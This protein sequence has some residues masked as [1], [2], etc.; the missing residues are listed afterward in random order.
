MFIVSFSKRKI[1]N[2]NAL[3][4]VRTLTITIRSF[5]D[6]KIDRKNIKRSALVVLNLL[7]Y[8][9]MLVVLGGCGKL[10]G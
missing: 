3:S 4:A 2:H 5:C 9:S 10:E 1:S 7:V 8:K 6:I